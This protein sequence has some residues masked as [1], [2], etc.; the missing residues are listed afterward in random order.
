MIL[1]PVKNLQ[2]A[3]QRLAVIL[4]QAS[5][6]ALAEAMVHDVL[7]TL[8]EGSSLPQVAVVTSDPFT[9][10]LAEQ[11]GFEIIRDENNRS[12]TDAIEMATALC[13]AQG[14]ESTLVIPGDIPLIQA[15]EIEEI[16]AKAPE[17]GSV[18]VPAADGRGTNAA[19]RKPAGLFPLRFGNDSFKPHYSAACATGE[20]CVV[21]SL[22]G[23]ALDVDNPGDLQQLAAAPG[24][25]RSQLLARK[26]DLTDYPL[27]ANE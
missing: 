19:W 18:L 23:I 27:A 22:P 7:E 15:R 13:E 1:I 25:R 24:E 6:T 3:K 26:W 4:D 14:V 9:I 12:E 17:Q 21:L 8:A 11:F 2:N 16:L 5:R 20:P 10:E